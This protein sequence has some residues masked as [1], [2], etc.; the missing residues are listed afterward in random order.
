V[1]S[2]LRLIVRR[3]SVRLQGFPRPHLLYDC[4]E[5]PSTVRWLGKANQS[6][7]VAASMLVTESLGIGHRQARWSRCMRRGPR[8]YARRPN[9]DGEAAEVGERVSDIR[10]AVCVA[11]A[12]GPSVESAIRRYRSGLVLRSAMDVGLESFPLVNRRDCVRDS[13]CNRLHIATWSASLFVGRS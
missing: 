8:S 7:D 13:F 1:S 5:Y 9:R 6:R 2:G 10:P 12:A 3:R 11:S 4:A